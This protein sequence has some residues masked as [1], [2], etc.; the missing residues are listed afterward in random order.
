MAQE[1]HELAPTA[2]FQWR[3]HALSN[4]VQVLLIPTPGRLV[5]SLQTWIGVGSAHDPQGLSGMAHLFEHL[6]F[7]G[8]ALVPD[9]DFDRRVEAMGGRTN[10]ATWLDWTFYYLD[11]PLDELEEAVFLESNRLVHFEL[12]E[13]RLSEEREV[14]LNE[15]REQVEDDPDGRLIEELWTMIF[16]DGAYGRPTLGWMEDVKKITLDDCRTFYARGYSADRVVLVLAGDVMEETALSLL[17][18][19]YGQLP[20]SGQR[21]SMASVGRSGDW[22]RR[23]LFL[24]TVGERFVL[25]ARAPDATHIDCSALQVINEVLLEG[26][27]SRLQRRLIAEDEVVAAA[28]GYL[29]LLRDCGVYEMGFDLRPGCSADAVIDR[30]RAELKSVVQNG[31][32][33]LE[34][35]RAKARLQTRFYRGLQTNQQ[36]AEALGYWSIV[37]EDAGFLLTRAERLDA[38]DQTAILRA[39]RR[40]LD[41]D[42]WSLVVAHPMGDRPEA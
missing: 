41:H 32:T 15:R 26:D 29:S 5:F 37:A 28:Y 35:Q 18:A 6:M 27:S 10:A 11:A 21:T 8:T 25:G 17:E 23:D 16:P 31:L 12:D 30:V 38:V 33:P 13:E 14:V 39:A 2:G 42:D 34:I 36:R 7:K 1:K 20:P 19:A 3:S 22:S 4:G 9:G 24:P 40:W